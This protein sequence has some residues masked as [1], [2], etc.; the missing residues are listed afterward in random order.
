M[1]AEAIIRAVLLALADDPPEVQ[2][3]VRAAIRE[4]QKSNTGGQL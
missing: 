1:T 3:K 2:A 4:A